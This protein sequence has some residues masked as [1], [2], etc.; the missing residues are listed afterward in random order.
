M[1]GLPDLLTS[2]TFIEHLFA[3][4]QN[5]LGKVVLGEFREGREHLHWSRRFRNSLMEDHLSQVLKD[6]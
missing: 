2:T 5:G 3:A 1:Q 4:L 6:G